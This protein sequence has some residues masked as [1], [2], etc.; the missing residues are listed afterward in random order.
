METL[1]AGPDVLTRGTL[2][3]WGMYKVDLEVNIVSIIFLY[4]KIIFN[5]L[6]APIPFIYFV[7][8]CDVDKCLTLTIITTV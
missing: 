7:K 3:L 8:E 2:D 4:I 1:H 5:K 6:M